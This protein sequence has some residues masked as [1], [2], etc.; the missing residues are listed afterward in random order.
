MSRPVTAAATPTMTDRSRSSFVRSRLR[1]TSQYARTV[2]STSAA[3]VASDQTAKVNN[4]AAPIS[5]PM[6]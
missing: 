5:H 1:R 4:T 2:A 6:R 3:D